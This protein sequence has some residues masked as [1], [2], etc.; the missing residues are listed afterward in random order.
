MKV[1]KYSKN[2]NQ[3]KIDWRRGRGV[4]ERDLDERFGQFSNVC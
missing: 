1:E 2:Q 4:L 3:M